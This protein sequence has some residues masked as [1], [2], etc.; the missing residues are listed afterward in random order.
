[1]GEMNCLHLQ[2]GK[3][4]RAKNQQEAGDKERAVTAVTT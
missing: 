1:M 4:G 3:E 2:V